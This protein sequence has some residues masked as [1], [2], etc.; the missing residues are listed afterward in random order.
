MI[1]DNVGGW[2]V[3][4]V[5]WLLISIAEVTPRQ[6]D[7]DVFES[8]LPMGHPANAGIV[9][10]LLDEPSWRIDREKPAMIDNRHPVTYSL[11]FFHGVRGEEDAPAGVA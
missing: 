10:V 5:G 4:T 6:P 8:D 2:A 3:E 11:G 9:L 7:E 1:P